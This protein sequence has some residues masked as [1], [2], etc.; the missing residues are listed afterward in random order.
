MFAYNHTNKST[1]IMIKLPT[2][3]PIGMPPSGIHEV[4]L[5]KYVMELL[6]MIPDKRKLTRTPGTMD[7]MVTIAYWII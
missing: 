7:T 1:S 2:L 4:S 6:T 5:F 3:Q